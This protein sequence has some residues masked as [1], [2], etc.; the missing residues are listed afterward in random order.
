MTV[1]QKK[2]KALVLG[3]YVGGVS[4][5]RLIKAYGIY[6]VSSY[7]IKKWLKEYDDIVDFEVL[8][9]EAE[10]QNYN[11]ILNGMLYELNH[12]DLDQGE[13][14]QIQAI[15]DHKDKFEYTY[16]QFYELITAFFPAV[17]FRG[18]LRIVLEAKYPELPY[19]LIEKMLGALCDIAAKNNLAPID[20]ATVFDLYLENCG[21][22]TNVNSRYKRVPL[23]KY[24]RDKPF[25][26]KV[27][28]HSYASDHLSRKRQIS[29]NLLNSLDVDKILV[30]HQ[31]LQLNGMYN[32]I[33]SELLHD[34]KKMGCSF[35]CHKSIHRFK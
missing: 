34:E 20:I 30:H 11:V 18:N 26:E 22:H 28:V 9:D 8:E 5:E 2:I 27:L 19:H 33:S 14:K 29:R 16:D 6:G 35:G 15:M 23:A 31:E 3:D 17:A 21:I 13:I 7:K 12:F 25:I 32:E 1:D 10:Y 4:K 24:L